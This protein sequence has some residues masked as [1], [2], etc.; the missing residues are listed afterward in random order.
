MG[1]KLAGD[2]YGGQLFKNDL[3]DLL[4]ECLAVGGV[5]EGMGEALFDQGQGFPLAELPGHAGGSEV[6]VG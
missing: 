2:G 5:Q 6:F 1:G 3:I 4:E